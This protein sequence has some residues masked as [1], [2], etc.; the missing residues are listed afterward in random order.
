MSMTMN[1]TQAAAPKPSGG[2]CQKAGGI[3]AFGATVTVV[4]STGELVDIAPT[5]PGMPWLPVH[6][7]AY[8]YLT[9]IS[10][11]DGLLGTLDVYAGSG[12][13]IWLRVVTSSYADRDYIEMTIGW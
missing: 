9:Q 7:G 2:V 1:V 11:G 13:I 3:G 10:G 8:R 5:A 4:C 12:T 6:G